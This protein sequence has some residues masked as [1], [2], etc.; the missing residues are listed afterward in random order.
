MIAIEPLPYSCVLHG[1]F[2]V[3]IQYP[4]ERSPISKPIIPSLS[5]N[6]VKCSLGVDN[7]DAFLFLNLE[8]RSRRVAS[9]AGLL[10]GNIYPPQGKWCGYFV[11]NVDI[12]QRFTPFRPLFK[13][14]VQGYSR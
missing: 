7:N 12:H 14:G 2:L 5:R 1:L 9:L 10:I 4:L 6:F 3:L 8:N 11:I 13:A